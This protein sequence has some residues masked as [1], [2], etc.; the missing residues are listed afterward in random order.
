[1]PPTRQ[2]KQARAMENLLPVAV[3]FLLAIGPIYGVMAERTKSVI[4]KVC[5]PLKELSMAAHAP[6]GKKNNQNNFLQTNPG[7]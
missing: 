2:N 3:T 6:F 7:L 5:G 4:Q 1:M